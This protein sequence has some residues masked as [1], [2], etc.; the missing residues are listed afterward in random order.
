[1]LR[2]FTANIGHH[3][4]IGGPTPGGMSH[5]ARDVFDEGLRIP[6]M[7]IARAGVVDSGL[8]EMIAVNTREPDERKLDLNVQIATNRRGTELVRDLA[9]KMGRTAMDEA[10]DDLLAYT[11]AR[12]RKCISD[13]PDGVYHG[14]DELDDDGV[15]DMPVPINVAVTVKGGSLTFDF[16]GTGP[17][18]RGGLNVAESALHATCY[19]AV[20]SL[21][22][23]E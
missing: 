3:G 1:E 13:L 21:L 8:L 12:M 6:L 23:P 10:V 4:D 18:S 22:D 5:S 11:E 9:L 20:K 17:Q 7:R 19:Y 14:Q 16:A 15:G 2:F